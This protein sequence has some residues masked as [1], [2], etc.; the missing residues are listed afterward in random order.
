MAVLGRRL[1]MRVPVPHPLEVHAVIVV[2]LGG[3]AV[4]DGPSVAADS[5][6]VIVRRMRPRHVRHRRR[7]SG[8][9]AAEG[10]QAEEGDRAPRTPHFAIL[11]WRQPSVK[12]RGMGELAPLKARPG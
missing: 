11:R 3:V 1:V 8:R 2:S 12:K 9:G 4:I 10:D 5:L 6:V 7:C